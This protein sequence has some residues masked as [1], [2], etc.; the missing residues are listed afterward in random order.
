MSEKS[1]PKLSSS[2]STG[3]SPSTHR[4]S[5]D[6]DK[7]KDKD[8]RAN[9]SV[10]TA[11]RAGTVAI[12]GA[13]NVGKS[14][15]LNALVG[16]HL[17]IITPKPQTTRDRIAGVLT[18]SAD[19]DP[20]MPDLLVRQ[21]LPACQIMFLDTPGLHK[22][23]NK[24][25]AYMNLEAEDVASSADV[26][27]YVAEWS[28]TPPL[29]DPTLT[30]I[31]GVLQHTDNVLLAI[32]K[33]DR[34]RDKGDIIPWL[35]AYQNMHK[36]AAYV[37]I[38]ASRGGEGNADGLD[39]LLLEICERLPEG[40]FVFD[41]DQL[42]DRPERYLAAEA[43]REQLMLLT[44]DEVPYAVAVQI[45]GWEEPSS[46]KGVTRIE[47]TIVVE[48]EAQRKI[49]IGQEGMRLKE[50]ATR[51]RLRIEELL[52]RKVFL[53]TFVRIEQAWSQNEQKLEELGY[54]PK[55]SGG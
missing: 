34:S 21:G 47:A 35:A 4:R 1:R 24:L 54:D 29:T 9:L 48:K 5:K 18:L 23:K 22:P 43:I 41:S 49:V 19:S 52:G 38:S 40:K 14:T 53:S 50:I 39:R 42:T 7:D 44:R 10:K 20:P 32:N 13:P 27:V 26:V 17:S 2:H 28:A 33:I 16:A 15:L 25:S 46:R 30:R 12:V 51:A 3:H 8:A 37:P 6:K 36:F 11:C 55:H 45:E 31:L